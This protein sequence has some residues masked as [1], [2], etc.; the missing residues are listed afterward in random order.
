VQREAELI[1]LLVACQRGRGGVS[2]TKSC[3]ASLS[4]QLVIHD[5]QYSYTP[6]P[7]LKKTTRAYSNKA[8]ALYNRVMRNYTGFFM[9]NDSNGR[10][11]HSKAADVSFAGPRFGI[12]LGVVSCRSQLADC[13]LEYLRPCIRPAQTSLFGLLQQTAGS[14]PVPS[15]APH[16]AP[17]ALEY[18]QDPLGKSC[19]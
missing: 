1:S 13:T 9:Y 5:S 12:S 3:C 17:S 2:G 7:R 6:I 16:S 14:A 15:R 18:C 4:S 10:L 19:S 8:H 11:W